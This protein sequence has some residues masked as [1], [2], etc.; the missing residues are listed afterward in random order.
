[1]VN[2]LKGF[3]MH[4]KKVRTTITLTKR[5]QERLK[6]AK[7][8]NMSTF[9]SEI[10]MGDTRS[11][12]YFID[13]ISAMNGGVDNKRIEVANGALEINKNPGAVAQR[14]PLSSMDLKRLNNAQIVQLINEVNDLRERL[15]NAGRD[16]FEPKV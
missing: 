13:Y 6:K 14:I 8:F 7:N 10:A 9:I 5:A 11:I 16:M 2:H 1:M 15:L 3:T 4:E 12:E